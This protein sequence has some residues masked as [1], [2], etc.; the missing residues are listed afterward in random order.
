[1]RFVFKGDLAG[2]Y[3]T[4]GEIGSAEIIL[5]KGEGRKKAVIGGL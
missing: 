4:W 5:G 2:E 3:L 1:M